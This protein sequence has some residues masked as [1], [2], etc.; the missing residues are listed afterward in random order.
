MPETGPFSFKIDIHGAYVVADQERLHSACKADGEVD[1]HVR[2]VEGISGS[3]RCSDEA[4]HQGRQR[5]A[6][7]L[8]AG[9]LYILARN[10]APRRYARFSLDFRA[11]PDLVDIPQQEHTNTQK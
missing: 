8:I 7:P 2:P 4:G 6:N 9:A 1:F 11:D 5:Q 10:P 3:S